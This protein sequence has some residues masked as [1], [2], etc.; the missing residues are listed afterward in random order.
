LESAQAVEGVF[1][2]N[3]RHLTRNRVGEPVPPEAFP[4]QGARIHEDGGWQVPPLQLFETG[5]KRA[6]VTVVEGYDRSGP[7]E[8]AIECLF[9]GH[10]AMRFAEPVE[11]LRESSARNVERAVAGRSLPLRHDVVIGQDRQVTRPPLDRGAWEA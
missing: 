9:Q 11:M 10:E 4:I 1:P 6:R 8:I 2:D 3:R 7:F 5:R